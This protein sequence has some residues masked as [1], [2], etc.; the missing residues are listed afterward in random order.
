MDTI[1]KVK[2]TQAGTR[3]IMSLRSE[4]SYDSKSVLKC[5]PGRVIW[6]AEYAGAA[7]KCAKLLAFSGPPLSRVLFVLLKDNSDRQAVIN[8][9][10]VALQPNFA[11][12]K[13]L[14]DSQLSDLLRSLYTQSLTGLELS[15]L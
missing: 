1:R 15:L 9:V 5:V 3:L 7:L 10:L 6:G 13:Y 14:S 2:N 8:V 12:A 11:T 4:F